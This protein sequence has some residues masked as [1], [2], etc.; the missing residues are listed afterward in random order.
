MSLAAPGTS[1]RMRLR[2][3]HLCSVHLLVRWIPRSAGAGCCTGPSWRAP[4]GTP[5]GGPVISPSNHRAAV[6]TAAIALTVGQAGV[7]PGQGRVL[8]R[9]WAASNT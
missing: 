2:L 9:A 8:H 3:Q 1:R 7:V 6:D 5:H 4:S